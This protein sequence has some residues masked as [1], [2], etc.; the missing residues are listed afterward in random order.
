MAVGTK[1]LINIELRFIDISI[2]FI[3][4]SNKI[5]RM[6]MK[7]KYKIYVIT[8]LMKNVEN[9]YVY[10]F[11]YE[12]DPMISF[13]KRRS[14]TVEG[15]STT[16]CKIKTCRKSHTSSAVIN[17]HQFDVKI[18]INFTKQILLNTKFLS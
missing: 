5:R 12:W 15:C 17:K 16:A 3:F 13:C 18:Y 9:K 11:V 10:C 4:S 14:R 6:E 8:F 2:I 1:V 7:K